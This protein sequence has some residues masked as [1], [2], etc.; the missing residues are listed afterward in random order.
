MQRSVSSSEP[1]YAVLLA[2]GE[3]TRMGQLKALLPWEG[4]PLLRY[5]ID[6]LLASPVERVVVVLGHRAGELRALLPESARLQ[7]VDNERYQTGKVSS[8]HAGVAALAGPGH[9]LILSVDQP[10][11]AG[12]LCAVVQ[13]HLST[14]AL[15]TIAAHGE[16][17]GHPVLFSPLLFGEVLAIDEATEGLR[18]VLG[19][20]DAGVALYDTGSPLARLNLNTP[21]DY[22]RA[23][24][25]MGHAPRP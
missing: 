6:Q 22:T 4:Q 3:S 13:H 18:A 17:R 7:A 20:H 23:T 16:R 15:I 1:V 2:A 24:A 11:P 10:R 9:L 5:Q 19:R 21:E 14:G 8:I 25:L 12:L